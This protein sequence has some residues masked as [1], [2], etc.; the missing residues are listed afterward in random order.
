MLG[1]EH[2]R[3]G[4]QADDESVVSRF[5]PGEIGYATAFDKGLIGHYHAPLPDGI[6]LAGV[7]EE[8]LHVVELLDRHQV[9]S[10]VDE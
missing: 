10:K 9:G 3:L 2:G 5:E 1:N 4:E 8:Y 6:K 7:L